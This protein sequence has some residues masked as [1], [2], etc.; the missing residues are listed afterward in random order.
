MKNTILLF[1]I[2]ISLILSNY[3]FNQ[4]RTLKLDF[5]NKKINSDSLNKIRIGEYYRVE[6]ENINLNLF[7]VSIDKRDSSFTSTVTFPTLEM[8]GLDNI[9]KIS[10][11]I[12]SKTISSEDNEIAQLLI[13]KKNLKIIENKLKTEV[14]FKNFQ[15]AILEQNYETNDAKISSNDE[16]KKDSLLNVFSDAKKSLKIDEI[17]DKIESVNLNI[18]EIENLIFELDKRI[19]GE[20]ENK[21][22]RIKIENFKNEVKT[23]I[24]IS[25]SVFED[26]NLFLSNLTL[27]S[28]VYME[29]LY[30][31]D[32]IPKMNKKL[33]TNEV[34][35]KSA[36]YRN[37]IETLINEID[38][39]NTQFKILKNEHVL[40]FQKKDSLND[41]ASK[42]TSLIVESKAVL[43]KELEKIN[44]AKMIEYLTK[45][46]ILEN[47]SDRR[48]LSMPLQHNGDLSKLTIL[49]TPK[50]PDYGQ[51][52]QT[53][54]NFKAPKFYVG[55]G[56]GFYYANSLRNDS[57]SSQEVK[58]TDTTSNFMIV[59]ENEKRGEFG[60]TTLLH[61]GTKISNSS[62]NNLKNLFGVHFSIGPAISLYSKP[63][64]RLATGFGVSIGK[65]K[66]M[67]AIDVLGM[68]GYV[69]RKSNVYN[70]LST[71]FS[72]P[73]QI[74]V[75]RLSSSFALSVGYIYKF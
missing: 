72:K 34:L 42:L 2:S 67:V 65:E 68:T 12:V 23:K 48:Y 22:I 62:D 14:E 73:D 51:G 54:Y 29:S 36:S 56:A 39:I 44:E 40:V 55:I 28:L 6:I 37:R 64:V 10:S 46:I 18:I 31:N 5:Q 25:K 60:F 61:I 58:L 66:N 4:T 53:T 15:K 27:Q 74:T 71:Y 52:Y 9:L 3:A 70:E 75:S 41:E 21:K 17:N 16:N 38:A 33:S 59:N 30:G 13:E 24:D 63:Q 26:I 7:N 50:N 43:E 49:I 57:Y 8:I 19:E 32:S 45:I 69:E 1:S 20:A 11:S 47:N 35:V